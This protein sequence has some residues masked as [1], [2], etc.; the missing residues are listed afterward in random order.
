MAAAAHIAPPSR[1]SWV[2]PE[3]IVTALKPLSGS[4][5][6]LVVEWNQLPIESKYMAIAAAVG[7]MLTL[8]VTRGSLM[9]A[10][11]VLAL[12]AGVGWAARQI[13]H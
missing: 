12:I 2:I 4:S 6:S 11:G 10:F 9:F 5:L 13:F 3:A 7:F 1:R 8:L